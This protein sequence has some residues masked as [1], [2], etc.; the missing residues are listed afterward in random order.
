MIGQNT[1]FH[2]TNRQHP[3][4]EI[5]IPVTFP[6][7]ETSG[8]VLPSSFCLH[9]GYLATIL[10][11][12]GFPRMLCR[13]CLFSPLSCRCF[14][15]ESVLAPCLADTLPPWHLVFAGGCALLPL[16]L[17]ARSIGLDSSVEGSRCLFLSF[18]FVPLLCS[19]SLTTCWW[20][21]ICSM[22]DLL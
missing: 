19:R 15:V 16:L 5:K 20:F 18:S 22:R 21:V 1:W 6:P 11:V 2:M 12:V 4:T 7:L 14:A 17:D 8:A 13:L 3:S 10:A 9:S